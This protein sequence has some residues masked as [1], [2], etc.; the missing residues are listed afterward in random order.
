MINFLSKIPNRNSCKFA[1]KLFGL[2]LW[3]YRK[4]IIDR[5]MEESYGIS[6]I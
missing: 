1:K 4:G 2:Y 3:N 5:E 6:N